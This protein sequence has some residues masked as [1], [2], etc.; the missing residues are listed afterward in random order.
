MV[1]EALINLRRNHW[2]EALESKYASTFKIQTCASMY[3]QFNFGDSYLK[4]KTRFF[5]FIFGILF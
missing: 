3:K 2:N 4:N 5:I 1:D